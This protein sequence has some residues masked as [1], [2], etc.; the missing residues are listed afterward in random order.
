M[1]RRDQ[2]DVVAAHCLQAEHHA[3][4]YLVS[5]PLA[6]AAVPEFPVLA[7]LAQEVAAAKENGAGTMAAHQRPFF[8]EVWMGG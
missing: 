3:P 8:T 6:V 5:H 7:V 4:E 2:I 1:R